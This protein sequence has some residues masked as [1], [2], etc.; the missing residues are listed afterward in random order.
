[1][2]MNIEDIK[3]D[4]IVRHTENQTLYV[5]V[6][7]GT[8]RDETTGNWNTGV[9]YVPHDA[10]TWTEYYRTQADMCAHFD[11]VQ[12]GPDAAAA[13]TTPP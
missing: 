2:T 13:A 11:F 6:G 9:R 1:M 5:I 7:I 10:S 8:L 3:V 4:T 12:H